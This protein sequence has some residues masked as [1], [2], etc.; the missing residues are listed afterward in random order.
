[1]IMNYVPQ[2][3]C[4]EFHSFGEIILLFMDN[5]CS[6]HPQL[7]MIDAE[8]FVILMSLFLWRQCVETQGAAK[9]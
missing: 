9:K 7:R 4:Q 2:D 5:C 1:M 3:V 6:C 8:N